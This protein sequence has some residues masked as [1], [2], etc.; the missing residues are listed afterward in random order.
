MPAAE[1]VN[2]IAACA[3]L[4][5]KLASAADLRTEIVTRI[6]PAEFELSD[7]PIW[8]TLSSDLFLRP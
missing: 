8:F 5:C 3:M 7:H 6:R 2:R 1:A 4:G